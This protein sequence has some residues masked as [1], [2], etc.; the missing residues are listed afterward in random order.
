[1][2]L[3][4]LLPRAGT[5]SL[6]FSDASGGATETGGYRLY[7]QRLN[8]PGGETPLLFGDLLAGAVTDPTEVDTYTIEGE[9][10]DQLIVRLYRSTNTLQ[11]WFRLYSPD[12]AFR[13]EGYAGRFVETG[14]TLPIAGTYTLLV[15]DATLGRAETGDYRLQVQRLNNPIGV[16]ALPYGEQLTAAID[17]AAEMDTYTFNGEVDETIVVRMHRTSN[18]LQPWFRLYDPKGNFVCQGFA[19]RFVETACDLKMAGRY[20]LVTADASSPRELTGSYGLY[21]QRLED[22]GAA[23]SIDS[24]G[25]WLTGGI[26]NAAEVDTFTFTG[27]VDDRLFIRMHR[28]SNLVQPWI[29]IFKPDGAFLC[30]GYGERL[31]ER[32]CVLPQAGRYTALVADATV[33][34]LE[35][36][37]Y[38]LYIQRLN[39]PG[40]AQPLPGRG[41]VSGTIDAPLKV[42]T[43][44]VSGQV[45]DQINL[46]M[47]R[48]FNTLQ[49]WI[50]VYN[51]GG[52]LLCQGFGALRAE[53]GS[54]TLPRTGIYTI[55]LADASTGRIET[56]GYSLAIDCLRGSCL[57]TPLPLGTRVYLPLLRR[58]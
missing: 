48:L 6:R 25:L 52:E 26:N 9:V 12:G 32:D 21:I 2:W 10:D 30:E 49:P 42:A 1:M 57:S 56:G 15:A 46:R 53:I 51:P 38:S 5:Y 39:N 41:M 34:R 31:F 16:T 47:V 14:C 3:F 40:T 19:E 58:R 55:L 17:P 45:D 20:T 24:F 18:T 23:T 4:A 28:T 8:Q 54:C 11:P 29:R 37:N 27:A 50:R 43:Y 35:T 44:T 22:P 36:G 13:C 7:L 33:G